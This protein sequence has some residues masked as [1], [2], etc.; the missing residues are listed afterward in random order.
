MVIRLEG[1]L[2]NHG[3]LYEIAKSN[4]KVISEEEVGKK[5]VKSK[6]GAET[7]EYRFERELEG[8]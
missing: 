5:K 7:N 2:N 8:R 1:K 6:G 3:I 4:I